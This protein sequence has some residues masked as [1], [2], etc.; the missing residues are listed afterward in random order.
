MTVTALL[1]EAG[2]WQTLEG[3]I[4]HQTGRIEG[5]PSTSS[6]RFSALLFGSLFL[7]VLVLGAS[8]WSWGR[9]EHGLAIGMDLAFGFGAL[10]TF[11]GWYRGSKIRHHLETVKSGNLVTARSG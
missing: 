7:I 1:G 2:N 8:F 4:D 10:Y 6:L 9:G 3:W 11:V 5:A